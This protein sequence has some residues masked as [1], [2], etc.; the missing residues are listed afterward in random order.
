MVHDR[1][2]RGYGG[3]PPKVIWP[4]GAR[5][6]VSVVVNVEE[7]AELSLGMGDERNESVYE[8]VEEVVGSRDLC[9]ESHFEYGP[10]AGWPRIRSLLSAY[11]V[12]ATLNAN[13]RAVA[14]SPWLA[15]EAVADGHEVAAH[16]WR[17]ERHAGMG[18]AEERAAIA[19]A[20]A[21]IRDATGR[22]P[23][24][25][26]TRS[27][28]SDNTRRL[29]MEQGGFLYDSNAYNDDLPY[30]VPGREGRPHVVLPY[31]FDTNDMR[32]QRGGG[33]VFGDDF[34][35]YCID[36]FDRLYAEGG[37]APRMLSV[38]LHL[39][40]IGRPGRIGGLERF[41]AHAAA[42]EGTWFARRDAI[43]GHWLRELA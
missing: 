41:L 1:D 13:G 17:W 28:T 33:F 42:H 11:G 23:V 43:A 25:W 4:G 31:A 6:A 5:L 35:R 14:L 39:R 37:D 2:F 20:V 32:F 3:R 36:A 24:G 30:L 8:V 19:K 12:A 40:I 7:G 16:G 38:G 26:H 22:A 9:M 10:R 29:L 34:A 21:A 27:A 15:Q 18:E